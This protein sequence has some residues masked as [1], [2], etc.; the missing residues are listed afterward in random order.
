MSNEIM[1][2]SEIKE[3]M[4]ATTLSITSLSEQMGIVSKKFA[5]QDERLNTVDNRIET[6]ENRMQAYEDKIRITREQQRQI[7][8]AIHSRVNY[9]LGLEFKGGVVARESILNDKKYRSGF[10]KRCYHDARHYS[11]LQAPYTETYQRDFEECINY[12]QNWIPEVTFEGL[13]GTEAY[14][15]YL[16]IR[17]EE[18]E[19]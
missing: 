4:Q 1:E 7:K 12:I 3:I 11:R 14:K 9:L 5:L 2:L 17:A 19:G 10:I 13:S 6:V 18:K 15:K 16:D 8:G